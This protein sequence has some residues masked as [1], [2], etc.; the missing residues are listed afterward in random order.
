VKICAALL[1]P[2][3]VWEEFLR[4]EGL[5]FRVLD[6]GEGWSP[7]GGSVLIVTRPLTPPDQETVRA[8]LKEGGGVLGC[9]RD[10]RPLAGV[11]AGPGRIQYLLGEG[12]GLSGSVA[13]LDLGLEGEIPR[14]ARLLRTEQNTFALFAG[15]L[16]GGKA[17]ILPFDPES[18]LA[19]GRAAVKNFYSRIERLPSERV[20][21]VAKGEVRHLLHHALEYLHLSRGLPY[22]H[23]WFFPEGARTVFGLRID[24]DAGEKRD[25]DALYALARSHGVGFT[26]FLDLESHAQFLAHFRSMVDQEFGVH[27]LAHAVDPLEEPNR[28][29]FGKAREILLEAGFEVR[30]LAAPYGIWNPA[31]ARVTVE[32]GFEY[33]SEFSWAYDTLPG[34]P[35]TAERVYGALQVPIHPIGVGSLRKAGH[36]EGQMRDYFS[37][38]LEWK[39]AR[40][41][42]L[43]FYHHPSDRHWGVLDE[44]L[45]QVEDRGA[46]KVTLGEY[47]SWWRRRTEASIEVDTRGDLLELEYDPGLTPRDVSLRVVNTQ[48][49]EA[50]APLHPRIS[51]SSLDWRERL[52][53]LPPGDLRRTREFDTRTLLADLHARMTRRAR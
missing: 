49:R 38:M 22:V 36:S 16:L 28:R 17:V 41:E 37:L 23:L 20:S 13:L 1:R 29:N 42:P 35:V 31:L 10:L 6:P 8:C 11:A 44:L 21:L 26:W 7:Q 43:F 24:T 30:G 48:G 14:E 18:A 2:S 47:A 51:L 3:S 19:D 45:R 50:L 12:M 27:C 52:T 32:L 5:P 9:A 4:Q 15:D 39:S 40:S 33:S 34:F 25:I 53:F 46:L